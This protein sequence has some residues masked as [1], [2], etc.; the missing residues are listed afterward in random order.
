MKNKENYVLK[1]DGFGFIYV[2][3]THFT[4][5][6]FKSNN[7]FNPSKCSLNDWFKLICTVLTTIT[8]F[9]YL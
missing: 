2:L 5:L 3:Y 9:I 4:I 6:K 1:W 7:S 8:Y